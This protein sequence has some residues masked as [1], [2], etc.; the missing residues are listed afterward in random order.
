MSK[1]Y[2]VINNEGLVEYGVKVGDI[3]S[4]KHEDFFNIAWFY[5]EN[6]DGDGVLIG[7]WLKIL[8]KQ[9]NLIN[10]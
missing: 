5:N 4:L 1:L 10:F 8:Q 9:T 6:W 3:C 2:R 7:Q